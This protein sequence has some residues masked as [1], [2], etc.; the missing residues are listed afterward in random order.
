M[1]ISGFFP[2]C[3]LFQNEAPT[4]DM[5]TINQDTILYEDN[6]L[7]VIDKPS[8]LA[9]MGLPEGGETLLT[10]AKEYIKRKYNKPGEVYLGV[11]SRLDF[12]VSGLIVFAR[13]S[14]AAAR[15]NEQFRAHS[16]RKIYR[17]LVEGTPLPEETC[18]DWICEDPRHRKMWITRTPQNAPD[19]KEAILHYTRLARPGAVT[20]LEIELKTGRKHQIRL[21]LSHRGYPVFGDFK[22]GSTVPFDSA[23]ALHAWRLCFTHPV[24]G[25][26]LDLTAPYPASWA[27]W[28]LDSFIAPDISPD[29]KKL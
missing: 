8:G 2:F 17:A 4:S 5:H 28:N 18:T 21:Q 6:H 20:L 7:L 16:V 13:T 11:V 23:I 14:K 15:L 10:R 12:P 25:V 26:I 27:R 3:S 29:L 24:T 22:Y 19:A 1:L 9:T